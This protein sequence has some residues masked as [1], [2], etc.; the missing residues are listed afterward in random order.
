MTGMQILADALDLAHRLPAT[1]AKV[2]ALAVAPWKARRLAQ[3][4]HHLS[5]RAA[6][7][8][9]ERLADRIDTCGS[10]LIDR[11]CAQAAARFDPDPVRAGRAGGQ[12]VV[13]RAPDPPGRRQLCRHLPSGG[14]RRQ[15]AFTTPRTWASSSG[16]VLRPGL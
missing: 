13:E 9:D 10:V 14:H 1:W 2:Q 15:L 8:V 16:P 3:A 5:A 11:T 12:A 4:S 6:A 7:Y